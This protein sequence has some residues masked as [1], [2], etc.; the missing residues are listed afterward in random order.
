MREPLDAYGVLGVPED[1][2]QA[3]LKDA[4]RQLAWR[5][6]P[7]R[8]PAEQRADATR[9]IQQINVAYG[10]VRTP[11]VRARYDTLRAPHPAVTG[12]SNADWDELMRQAGRWAAQWWRRNEGPL[13]RAATRTRRR[14]TDVT[15][16]VTMVAFSWMG[17]IL[18]SAAVQVMQSSSLL[19][20]IVGAA[21]GGLA[22]AARRRDRLR[23]LDG[24][25]P[26]RHSWLPVAG[27]LVALALTLVLVA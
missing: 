11:A 19:P 5:H 12:R 20:T 23:T 27:W 3:T 21:G 7:D 1:A 2:D 17:L 18:A 8:L 15:G 13:R 4:H 14:Y 25:P 24:H 6:H 22:G 26:M 10:L 16:T 9:R